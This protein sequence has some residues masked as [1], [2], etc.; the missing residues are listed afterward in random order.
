M[1]NLKNQQ[2]NQPK[3]NEIKTQIQTDEVKKGT[4]AVSGAGV[5]PP[6]G[7]E[8]Q[9]PELQEQKI[10]VEVPKKAIK[11]K[12][13]SSREMKKRQRRQEKAEIKEYESAKKD[14]KK[15]GIGFQLDQ[16]NVNVRDS[17]NMKRIKLLLK[18]YLSV[19]AEVE[20]RG[21]LG[22]KQK[23]QE[24]VVA[25]H[26]KDIISADHRK[27]MNR[28]YNNLMLEIDAYTTMKFSVFKSQRGKAR[29]AQV[30]EIHELLKADNR[31]YMLSDFRRM[32]A[33]SRDDEVEAEGNFPTWLGMIK[34]KDAIT[35]RNLA[36]KKNKVKTMSSEW[37]SAVGDNWW[38]RMEIVGNGIGGFLDRTVAAG[39]MLGVNTLTLGGKVIKAPLKVMSWITN[40]AMRLFRSEKRWKVDYSLTRGWT[41]Y[42]ESRHMAR[43]LL[44]SAL[45]LP[46]S[47]LVEPVAV[48][49]SRLFSDDPKMKSRKFFATTKEYWSDLGNAIAGK[50]KKE[51]TGLGFGKDYDDRQQEDMYMAGDEYTSN[52]VEEE[53]EFIEK[54]EPEE[55]ESLRSAKE[56]RAELSALFSRA[57]TPAVMEQ[58][59]TL[60][61]ELSRAIEREKELGINTKD[62]TEEKNEEKNNEK[63]EDEKKEVEK[64]EDEKKEDEKK[65][66]ENQI[67][68]NKTDE[69]KSDN[70]KI[71]ENK[72][73]IINENIINENIINENVHEDRFEA[74]KGMY[75][76][77]KERVV[78][79]QVRDSKGK[80]KTERRVYVD[81]FSEQI[82]ADIAAEHKLQRI[83]D[84]PE[85]FRETYEQVLQKHGYRIP[86]SVEELGK[87]RSASGL[88]ERK[89]CTK[90]VGEQPSFDDPSRWLWKQG[91]DVELARAFDWLAGYWISREG[92]GRLGVQKQVKPVNVPRHKLSIKPSVPYESQ[93]TNNC[94]CC[95][96]AGLYN[97]FV[98]NTDGAISREQIMKQE[99]VRSFEPKLRTL[100]E[101][102]DM[103]VEMDQR[104][105]SAAYR[106]ITDYAGPK[107]KTM[108]NIFEVADFFLQKRPDAQMKRMLITL[109]A[110]RKGN[111]SREQIAQEAVIYNNQKAVF[112]NQVYK[113]LSQGN[114]VGFLAQN[115]EN[116]QH[117]RM[118][119]GIDGETVTIYDSLGG[120]HYNTTV[121]QI[122]DRKQAGNSIELT[123]FEKL[124]DPEELKKEYSNLTYSEKD[125]FGVKKMQTEA[126]WNIG[127]T[128]GVCVGKN[129]AEMGEGMDGVS[130]A[131]YVPK[132]IVKNK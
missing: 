126:A 82:T 22:E 54:S 81:V 68:E 28:L 111:K 51:W 50:L 9:V 73:N 107:K 125:G 65:E 26:T 97:Q 46:T 76:N 29:L 109:P 123:W 59:Q 117:Y 36:L 100:N 1:P 44:K 63:K 112:M 53:K 10:P 8:Q 106:A 6:Q 129:A 61:K 69:K 27:L 20:A 12:K 21:K 96:A 119:T 60:T 91:T 30:K 7:M 83:E 32:V 94:W 93:T 38:N 128:Q 33:D 19:K 13:L 110:L 118:I 92:I 99:H 72:I 108:G 122:M 24:L 62:Q 2:V 66:D 71:N 11:V 25:S 48:G 17:R 43:S 64:K 31:R 67:N 14:Y 102:R 47:W 34:S 113:V 132:R 57:M 87:I 18:E 16:V 77:D 45:I 84:Y 5:V 35:E 90:D 4:Q 95:T 3:A 15:Y 98:K 52:E 41:G 78:H 39:V 37:W 79:V 42:D 40:G 131:V 104:D 89:F 116:V 75:A 58:I 105:Y 114:F 115:K 124:Q 23:N 121:G 127:Q 55:K 86:D 85:R 101:I 103:G 80:V 130:I 74:G 70:N 56:I 120:T 88:L 49:A